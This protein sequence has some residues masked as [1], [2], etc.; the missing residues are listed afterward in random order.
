[1][2]FDGNRYR[3]TVSVAAARRPA[4][5]LSVTKVVWRRPA[6]PMAALDRGRTIFDV[7]II[8]VGGT[9]LIGAHVAKVLRERGHDVTTAARSGADRVLD[10]EKDAERDL[11]PLLAGQDGVVFAARTD[12]QRPLRKPIYPVFR[13]DL[14]DPVV[15]LF[16]AARAQGLTRAVLMGSYYTYFDRIRPQWR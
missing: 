15:R 10:L 9:G 11:R 5:L 16:T 2:T 3:A 1:M 12:E 6:R 13:R 7:R 8:V 14:V 4:R